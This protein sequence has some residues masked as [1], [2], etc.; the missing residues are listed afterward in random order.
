VRSRLGV[1]MALAL[2][3]LVALL[4]SVGSAEAGESPAVSVG[5]G[6]VASMEFAFAPKRLP[7]R[8]A[9]IR[10]LVLGVEESDPGGIPPGISQVTFGI[11][12]GIQL[13]SPGLPTCPSKKSRIQVDATASEEAECRRAVVGRA[14]AKILFAYPENDPITVISRG[15]IYN[16]GLRP[17]GGDLV[18]E[19]PVG[20]PLSATLRL[21]VP[22]EAVSKG[23]GGSEIKVKFPKIAEGYG[24][25]RSLRLEV[26][27][28]YPGA[29][30]RVNFVDAGCRG[31]KLGATLNAALG[32][33]TRLPVESI[34]AC[35]GG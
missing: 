22:V 34:R 3:A 15:S 20:M 24:L 30:G 1:G 6:S 26:G 18:I 33:G 23:E 8:G 7:A 12:K 35:T 21:V 9:Q 17:G 4:V 10:K 31:G 5:D 2:V 32:D 27:R 29:G 19:L 16:A 25:L 13:G 14:E 28:S 11:D